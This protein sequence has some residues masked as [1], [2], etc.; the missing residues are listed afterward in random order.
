MKKAKEGQRDE[1]TTVA[2][3]M[4]EEVEKFY[5]LRMPD[6]FFQFWEFCKGLNANCPQGICVILIVPY[7]YQHY[8]HMFLQYYHHMHPQIIKYIH[9]NILQ[10]IHLILSRCTGV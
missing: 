7:P 5:K 3:E 10:L 2:G 9:I 4:R 6:D 8:S 1:K